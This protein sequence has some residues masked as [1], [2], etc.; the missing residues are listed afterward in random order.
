MSYEFKY[1]N[2]A[3]VDG[4]IYE[5]VHHEHEKLKQEV[6]ELLRLMSMLDPNGGKERNADWPLALS[7][8]EAETA[9]VCD[10]LNK[11]K[12]MVR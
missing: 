1:L 6:R 3:P 9:K 10:C 7:G 4:S 2:R 5:Y 12:E 11:L 8:D